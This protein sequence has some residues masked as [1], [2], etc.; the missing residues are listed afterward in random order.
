MNGDK[1]K[2][3]AIGNSAR[4]RGFPKDFSSLLV[5]YDNS[6][7]AW[8]N[9]AIMSRW[10]TKWNKQL[11]LK[12]KKVLLLLDN[13]P[14]HPN[15]TEISDLNLKNITVHYLPPQYHFFVSVS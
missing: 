10:L 6:K 7:K 8:M 2:L 1:K 14:S 4:P 9:K 5:D 12:D 3:L 15:L 13:T 11:R